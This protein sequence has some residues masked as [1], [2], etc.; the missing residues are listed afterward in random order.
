M[1]KMT[2]IAAEEIQVSLDESIPQDVTEKC[3]AA[4]RPSSTICASRCSP[5]ACG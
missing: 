3:G 2:T 4:W 1:T 5:P